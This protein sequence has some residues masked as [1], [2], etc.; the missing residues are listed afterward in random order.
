[1]TP[2]VYKKLSADKNIECDLRPLFRYIPRLRKEAEKPCIEQMIHLEIKPLQASLFILV[3]R[4]WNKDRKIEGHVIEIMGAPGTELVPE[5]KPEQTFAGNH[6]F[7]VRAR[8]PEQDRQRKFRRIL[9]ENQKRQTTEEE[10]DVR[11]MEKIVINSN[12][13]MNLNFFLNQKQKK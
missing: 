7:F 5:D 1:M 4:E 12:R 8:F 10:R 11:P 3:A 6:V 9:G 2:V 13:E